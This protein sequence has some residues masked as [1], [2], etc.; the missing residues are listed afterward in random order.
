MKKLSLRLKNKDLDYFMAKMRERVNSY[1]QQEQK[2]PE[3][4]TSEGVPDR[5][6]KIS[7]RSKSGTGRNQLREGNTRD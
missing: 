5:G 2:E 1:H 6:G 7:G 3:T 4:V